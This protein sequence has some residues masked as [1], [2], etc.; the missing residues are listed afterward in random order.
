MTPDDVSALKGLNFFKL[1][2][3]IEQLVPDSPPIGSTVAPRLEAVRFRANPTLGFPAGEIAAI[4]PRDGEPRRLDVFVNLLGLHGPS[5]PLAP[6]YTERVMHADGTSTVGDFLDFFNHRLLGLL[7]QSWKM[8]RHE[9]RFE[10]GGGDRT[11]AAMAALMGL[12]VHAGD[13]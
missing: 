7:Y 3:Q 5:S 8:Q 9:L 12:P 13:E 1:A 10:S 2:S 11:S 6:H 4:V